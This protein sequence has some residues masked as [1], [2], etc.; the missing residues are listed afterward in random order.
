MASVR[1]LPS[2][3]YELIG[4]TES[5]GDFVFSDVDAGTYTVEISAPGFLAVR[6]QVQIKGGQ[7]SMTRYVVMKPK[8]IPAGSL[9]RAGAMASGEAA[10]VP[11]KASWLPADVDEAIPAVDPA[12]DCPL[13]HILHSV[14][15][16]MK[17]F[18][19]NLEKFTAHERVEHFPVDVMGNRQSSQLRN[20][21]YVVTVVHDRGGGFVLD[22]YRNGSADPSQFPAG[23][24]TQGL[25]GL[26]LL[27]HP[28]LSTDFKFTCEGLGVW[29]DRA[30]WQVHFVQRPDRPGRIMGYRAADKYSALPLKG[31]AWIDPENSQVLRLE[32]ELVRPLRDMG[33]SAQYTAISYQQVQ[34]RKLG[35]QLWLPQTADLYVERQWRR[36]Y[37]RHTYSDFKLFVVDTDEKMQLAQESYGFTNASDRDIAGVLTVTPVSGAKFD[38]VSLSFTIPAGGSVVKLVGPGKDV[39]IPVDSVAAATFA[40]NGPQDSIKVDAHLSKESTLDIISGVATP[41]QP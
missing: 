16:R 23:I 22:E 33:L 9:E 13:P 39:G 26:A 38:P 14:G 37:R 21:E 24:A 32:S 1:V 10:V 30:A 27:F 11:E 29:G 2:E 35:L 20:F 12:V 41:L 17:Q 8:P 5:D 18:V 7:R 34:F 15:Q 6:Q 4:A 25:P 40:H 19:G 36:Y 28:A 31:R 3:G